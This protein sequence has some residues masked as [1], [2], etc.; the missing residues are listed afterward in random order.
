MLQV[1]LNV[2]FAFT[3][4]S[5][6]ISCTVPLVW[7]V[8]EDTAPQSCYGDATNETGVGTRVGA[9]WISRYWD[10]KGCGL[11]GWWDW[12]YSPLKTVRLSLTLGSPCWHMEYIFPS[13]RKELAIGSTLGWSL[14]LSFSIWSHLL[15]CDMNLRTGK[16]NLGKMSRTY[17]L[18]GMAF[19][20]RPIYPSIYP[21]GYLLLLPSE[22]SSSVC[23]SSIRSHGPS[24]CIDI[25]ADTQKNSGSRTFEYLHQKHSPYLFPEG[26]F[27]ERHNLF[28]FLYSVL[29][30]ELSV[31]NSR[32]RVHVVDCCRSLPLAQSLVLLRNEW[33]HLNMSP[34]SCQFLGKASLFLLSAMSSAV[35]WE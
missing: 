18:S 35:N 32:H 2:R 21:F 28:Y 7:H 16:N 8:V 3:F 4:P 34:D 22:T 1:W 11:G 33:L 9:Q 6:K 23:Q 27:S 13:L 12:F 30:P 10:W 26:Q 19:L 20:P 31:H 5:C 15:S 25:W 29:F 24:G 14:S 17:D